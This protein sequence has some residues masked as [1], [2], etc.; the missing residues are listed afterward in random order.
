MNENEIIV[1]QS[2]IMVKQQDLIDDLVALLRDV[3]SLL[4]QHQSTDAEE[5]RLAEMMKQT[6]WE[7]QL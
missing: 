2:G 7:G 6:P 1:Q 5:R 3:L 4:A